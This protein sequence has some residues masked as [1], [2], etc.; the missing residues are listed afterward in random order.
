MKKIYLLLLSLCV[1]ISAGATVNG[2]MSLMLNYKDGRQTIVSLEDNML[3]KVADGNVTMT[4]AKGSV[5]AATEALNNWKYNKTA[6]EDKDNGWNGI[7][8]INANAMQ[9]TMS[10]D[11]IVISNAPAGALINVVSVD[12]K[13][14]LS[15]R[16]SD[17]YYEIA[18]S[19]LRGGIYVLTI[20]K[21]SYKIAVK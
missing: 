20:N 5:V 16:T 7:E 14:I 10:S 8:D 19:G 3:V 9:I 13:S 6:V 17:G 2:Y 1:G 4:S 12:G 11:Y 21:E 15:D 18:T